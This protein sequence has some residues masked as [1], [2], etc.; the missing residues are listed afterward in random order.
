M[1][2]SAPDHEASAA[3]PTP[4]DS[5]PETITGPRPGQRMRNIALV[6]PVT[7]LGPWPSSGGSSLGRAIQHEIA[8]LQLAG[9][10]VLDALADACQA[11]HH[12]SGDG[13]GAAGLTFAAVRPTPIHRPRGSS[14]R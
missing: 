12:R 2:V 7:R 6:P 9:L 14:C 11:K 13:T 4:G 10:R 8:V 1:G 3:G 5:L